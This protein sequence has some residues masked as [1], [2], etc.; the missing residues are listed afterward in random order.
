MI[1]SS[2]ERWCIPIDVKMNWD[3]FKP[4]YKNGQ[5]EK[6][7]AQRIVDRLAGMCRSYERSYPIIVVIQ[8]DWR[9][10]RK[11]TRESALSIFESTRFGFELISFNETRHQ[12]ES[13]SYFR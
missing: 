12:I 13:V 4:S 8:G 11:S 5:V 9:I 10:P 1:S 2:Q 7:E 3:Q 6:S